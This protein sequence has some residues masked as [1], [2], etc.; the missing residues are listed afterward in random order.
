MKLRAYPLLLVSGLL[1]SSCISF[2]PSGTSSDPDSSKG[3]S[4]DTSS[5]SQ[6]GTSQGTSEESSVDDRPVFVFDEST[7][8]KQG[9]ERVSILTAEDGQGHSMRLKVIYNGGHCFTGS[10]SRIIYNLDPLPG[11]VDLKFGFSGRHGEFEAFCVTSTNPLN[12]NAL[13]S[14]GYLDMVTSRFT[15]TP[16]YTS[17]NPIPSI[18]LDADER[19]YFCLYTVE[20]AEETLFPDLTSISLYPGQA[21]VEAPDGIRYEAG[22]DEIQELCAKLF[23]GI[24]L[25]LLEGPTI[26]EFSH[27]SEYYL[28][29]KR[30]IPR[31]DINAF[32]T[33]LQHLGF[34]SLESDRA[35]RYIFYHN[36]GLDNSKHRQLIL[37]VESPFGGVNEV[38]F[39][40][41]PESYRVTSDGWPS[42]AISREQGH[43]VSDILPAP[44]Y[45]HLGATYSYWDRYTGGFEITCSLDKTIENAGRI[46]TFYYAE[47]LYRTGW[48]LLSWNAIDNVTLLHPEKEATI[49]VQ[50]NQNGAFQVIYEPLDELFVDEFPYQLMVDTLAPFYAQGIIPEPASPLGSRY[51]TY[52]S[53][54]NEETYGD[55]L[56]PDKWATITIFDTDEAAYDEYRDLIENTAALRGDAW[57]PAFIQFSD[58]NEDGVAQIKIEN[59]LYEYVKYAEDYASLIYSDFLHYTHFPDE[60][61]QA[62]IDI[63]ES[64]VS[65]YVVTEEGNACYSYVDYRTTDGIFL[66][67]I[68]FDDFGTA[69][70]ATGYDYDESFKM[71][72][73]VEGETYRFSIYG[74]DTASGCLIVFD[75]WDGTIP[76]FDAADALLAELASTQGFPAD[77][78]S[79]PEGAACYMDQGKLHTV[80]LSERAKHQAYKQ[81]K[82]ALYQNG[83]VHDPVDDVF[84]HEF[85]DGKAFLTYVNEEEGWVSYAF[86][87][88]SPFNDLTKASSVSAT[89][90]H[91]DL[92]PITQQDVSYYLDRDADITDPDNVTIYASYPFDMQTF[93]N[94]LRQ[95]GFQVDP[96]DPDHITGNAIVS[97]D[98]GTYYAYDIRIDRTRNTIALS[99]EYFDNTI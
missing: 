26:H 60:V 38:T 59:G 99:R 65:P 75:T 72:L 70:G 74:H 95:D 93:V 8:E 45:E 52:G 39:Q 78:A 18:F 4:S 97:H 23:D 51:C 84:V 88:T 89:R 73:V 42:T 48:R 91:L 50:K 54:I 86:A 20:K 17:F 56:F 11:L 10:T 62:F 37:E 64:R 34:R 22:N 81:F 98:T 14:E 57:S 16:D 58:I 55:E 92:L 27:S 44:I 96:F 33:E 28:T 13:T 2:A 24:E 19:A 80:Y 63:V 7:E 90:G 85:Q 79:Y 71:S 5:T 68:S 21:E 87:E 35:N 76:P 43:S 66:R 77:K 40:L 6:Q 31:F 53:A 9:E 82:A 36:T 29:F 15:V 49:N 1:L 83:F 32:T 94:R 30:Y 61:G 12:E 41:M 25:P 47:Q 3:G 46:A 67:G 69:I